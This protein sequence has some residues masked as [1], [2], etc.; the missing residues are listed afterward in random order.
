MSFGIANSTSDCR[1]EAADELEAEGGG[2]SRCDCDS[3]SVG[4][5]QKLQPSFGLCS[6]LSFVFHSKKR[7]CGSHGTKTSL[8]VIR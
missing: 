5:P 1:E 8:N 4:S 6:L 3:Q 2:G 7:A